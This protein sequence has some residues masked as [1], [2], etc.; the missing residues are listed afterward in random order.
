MYLTL[1]TLEVVASVEAGHV[2]LQGSRMNILPPA[3]VS[4]VFLALSSGL[5]SCTSNLKIFLL[6]FLLFF[7]CTMSKTSTTC[8]PP[9][10]FTHCLSTLLTAH[11]FNQ[12]HW[13]FDLCATAPEVENING[14][15]FT[16][17]SYSFPYSGPDTILS[18]ILLSTCHYIYYSSTFFSHHLCCFVLLSP[19]FSIVGFNFTS[20]TSQICFLS[21]LLHAKPSCILTL[22]HTLP[23]LT[24]VH[25]IT[26]KV[27]LVQPT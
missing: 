3:S 16:T 17:H 14:N 26:S 13:P 7:S 5:Q 1:E 15:S 22:H 23:P 11:S 19:G 18:C 2:A 27:F 10:Y 8:H 6:I 24:T 4:C 9:H 20:F 21:F 12:K 25:N